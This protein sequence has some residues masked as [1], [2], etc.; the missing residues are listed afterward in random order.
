MDDKFEV[1]IDA[2]IGELSA[3]DLD[4]TSECIAELERISDE[5]KGALIVLESL[6][7]AE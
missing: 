2:W 3:L 7:S 4:N 1:M 6:V 5:M